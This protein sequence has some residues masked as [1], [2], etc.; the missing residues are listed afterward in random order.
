MTYITKKLSK[1]KKKRRGHRAI[2]PTVNAALTIVQLYMDPEGLLC[3]DARTI[4][5]LLA[6]VN[7]DGL[8]QRLVDRRRIRS[9]QSSKERALAGA[10]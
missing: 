8:K 3:L 5:R 7:D 4:D 6:I 2:K 1:D 10:V 9:R